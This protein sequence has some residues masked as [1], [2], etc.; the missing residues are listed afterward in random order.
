MQ[1]LTNQN[2]VLQDK[3]HLA[4]FYLF[5]VCLWQYMHVSMG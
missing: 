5:I 2:L 4:D 1:W 3:K